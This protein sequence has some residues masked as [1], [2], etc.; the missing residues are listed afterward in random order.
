MELEG[1]LRAARGTTATMTMDASF[2]SM[3]KEEASGF[4]S[5]QS[6]W[7]S[8][9]ARAWLQATMMA[10]TEVQ[11]V[12]VKG[13]VRRAPESGEDPDQQEGDVG[14]LHRLYIVQGHPGQVAPGKPLAPAVQEEEYQP[15]G[16]GIENGDVQDDGLIVGR[17]ALIQVDFINHRPLTVLVQIGKLHRRT[18]LDFALVHKVEQFR[19]KICQSDMPLYLPS[20]LQ[21]MQTCSSKG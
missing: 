15:G 18:H 16:Q 6:W 17:G 14:V 13:V 12:A 19:Y 21:T 5:P 20:S 4:R 2:R 3:A 9:T 7:V 8:I 10:C 1:A 11:S